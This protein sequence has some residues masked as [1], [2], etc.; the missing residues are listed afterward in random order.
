MKRSYLRCSTEKQN[1]IRQLKKAMEELGIDKEYIYLDKVS[2]KSRNN[3]IEL[4]R[5]LDDTVS[6]DEIYV[7]EISRLARSIV[8]LKSLVDEIIDKGASI[9]FIKE[10]MSFSPNDEHNPVK[11]LMFNMLG[12][13]AEFE[14]AI[15][16]SRVR[17]G[18]AIAKAQ[19][20]YKGR[21]TELC[22]G[23]K[24]ET[25][26]KAIVNAINQDMPIEEI[27]KIYKV[28]MGQIYRIKN[29]LKE[30]ELDND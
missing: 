17:E 6:G 7:H 2:G 29:E 5:L 3:R 1:E 24:D 20:K 13:F 28:G 30:I 27:R 25:R 23:G 9:H 21:K 11:D 10:N 15:I 16:V 8:D 12:A 26:Y 14:R 4:Q 19:G 18:V 22:I